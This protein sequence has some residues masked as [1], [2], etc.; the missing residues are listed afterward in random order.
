MKFLFSFAKGC[1]IQQ[2][3]YLVSQCFAWGAA[4]SSCCCMNDLETAVLRNEVLKRQQCAL[5]MCREVKGPRWE[6]A[7]RPRGT[8]EWKSR[9]Q[10]LW[11][12]QPSDVLFL[13]HALSV[14][15][16]V[17]LA[18]VKLSLIGLFP[19]TFP[20]HHGC[21]LGGETKILDCTMLSFY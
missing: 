17:G 13:Q 14:S 7:R 21:N 3:P 20:L 4:V 19:N 1:D 10:S 15:W 2:S 18:S 8:K 16:E 6:E 9:F 5:R 11:P 12:L